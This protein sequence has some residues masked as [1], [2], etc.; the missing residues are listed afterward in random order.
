MLL[1]EPHDLAGLSLKNLRKVQPVKRVVKQDELVL[2]M[3]GTGDDV[4]FIQVSPP[5]T[6]SPRGSGR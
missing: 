1:F 6:S 2:L 5:A 3:A 4:A